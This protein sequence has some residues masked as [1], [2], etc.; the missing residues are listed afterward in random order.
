MNSARRVYR[1][2]L[3]F[4]V[5]FASCLAAQNEARAYDITSNL[6]GE[7][8]LTETSG[9]TA[10]DSTSSNNGTYTNGPTLAASAAV[11]GSGAVAATFDGSN[12]YVA[13]PNQSAFNITGTITVAAWIKVSSFTS[14]WQAI[15]TKGDSAWR[16]SRNNA[17]NT[18][19]FD[20]TGLSTDQ[21]N[22]AISVNDG[23]WHHVVGVYDGSAMKLYIDGVLDTSV[24]SSGTIATNTFAVQ[25]GQNAEQAGRNWN[26][27]IYDVRVYSRALSASDVAYLCSQGQPAARWKLDESSGTSAADSTGYSHSGTVTGTASW[28]AA[29]LNN[30]FSFNGSTKIQATGLINSPRNA[31]VTAWANLTTADASGA[32]IVSLGD[33]FGLRLDTGGVSEV[34]FYNG[35]TYVTAA[36][37]QT[38]AGTG[39]HHFAG[40]FDDDNDNLKLYVD[41]VQVA[42]TST[43]NSISYS[44]LGSNT[45]IGRHGNGNTTYDFT[46]MIDDVRVYNYALS[47]MEVAQRYGLI[48]RWKLTETS[49]TTAIDSSPLAKNGT[50]T[51]GATLNQAGPYPGAGS[52]AAGFNGSTAYVNGQDAMNYLCPDGFSIS[53]WVYLNSYYDWAAILEVGSSTDSCSLA[54]SGTGQLHVIGRASDGQHI[55]TTNSTIPLSQW[56][57]V[58]ATHDGTTFKVYIDGVLVES[59]ANAFTL[60]TPAGNITLGASL[61]ASDDYL[62]C[63]LYDV[64]LYNR[65]LNGWEVA[66][67]HGLVGNWKLAETSGT[68]AADSSLS[69]CDGTYTNGVTVNSAGPYPNAG[70]VAAS[71]DGTND[72]VA[73]PNEYLYDISSA[74][75]I[76]GWFKVNSFTS[77]D[78]TI[79]SKGNSAW[80]LSRSGTTN[81]LK[82]SA[83]GLTT[84]SVTSTVNVNDGHWHHAVGVYDGSALYLYVDGALNSSASA[85]GSISTNNYNVAIGRNE[86]SSGREFNGSLFDVRVY[87]RAI[88]NSDIVAWHG[89]IGRWK[90]TETSGTT[91]TDSTL[92]ANHGAYQNGASLAT[93]S[94]VPSYHVQA[95]VL[96][97]TDDQVVIPNESLYDVTGPISVAAWIRVNAFS[98]AWQAAITKGDSSW[99]LTRENATNTMMFDCSGLSTPKV[100]STISVNDARWHHVAGVYDGSSLKFYVDGQLDQ[101]VSTSGNVS[102]NSYPVYFGEN[103]EATGRHWNGSLYDVRVY[104]RAISPDEVSQLYSG[105]FTGVTI[106]KW[107]E[108]Q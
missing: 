88:A 81:Y 43:T 48:G 32:E 92:Y 93:S 69:H 29:V 22:G 23:G 49:G 9:T 98:P 101:T 42:S 27:A 66:Q 108:S 105:G 76:G 84:T 34:F 91:A 18:I 94:Q 83:T 80:A 68:S 36:V 53:G 17:T 78:Q 87:N 38:F 39:W 104:N 64:R 100:V 3:Q 58:V 45:V 107:V 72:Y 82:F 30:G 7:W 31:S 46:G 44:G 15:V 67:L 103:A 57:H 65:A 52:K 37:N 86:E 55:Y 26:G 63:R 79:I 41:G 33:H 90:L 4:V 19:H 25:I 21:V 61:Y 75:A 97:G 35:S 50:Y 47:A 96:D 99:R 77:S 95:E 8:L 5:V 16:L 13:I 106:T 54:I 14:A 24:A 6:K 89:L 1:G 40:V 59:G 73:V 85:T 11:P 60:T 28:T 102:T 71:F 70:N 62:N 74:I 20:C 51:G 2:Y 56:K 12:D 10:N